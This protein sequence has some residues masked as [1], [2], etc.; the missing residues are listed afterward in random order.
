[1]QKPFIL[2]L[3]QFITLVNKIFLASLHYFQFHI[4]KAIS[5][6]ILLI[7]TVDFTLFFE[8]EWLNRILSFFFFELNNESRNISSYSLFIIHVYFILDIF[9]F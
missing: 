7:E 3:L 8:N 9:V 1:M 4:K 6:L 5:L 2:V